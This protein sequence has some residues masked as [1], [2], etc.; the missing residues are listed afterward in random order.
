[1]NSVE[2]RTFAQEWGYPTVAALVAA[3]H[4]LYPDLTDDEIACKVL[5]LPERRTPLF[6]GLEAK[7]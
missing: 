1:M 3:T 5:A 6:A 7:P 2:A 4:G